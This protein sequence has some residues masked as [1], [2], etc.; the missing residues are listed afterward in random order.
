MTNVPSIVI[1]VS[2]PESMS[3]RIDQMLSR[4]NGQQRCI[5]N[6]NSYRYLT[7]GSVRAAYK[8]PAKTTVALVAQVGNSLYLG[9]GAG[10][11]L[12]ASPGRV[13]HVLQPFGLGKPETVAT[14]L[15][16]W[17][18]ENRDTLVQIA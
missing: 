15:A 1:N 5:D 2:N 8:Y 4:A 3:A 6:N 17:V 10:P 14:K 11:A 16:A 12:A 7:G 18:A 9:I 13:W